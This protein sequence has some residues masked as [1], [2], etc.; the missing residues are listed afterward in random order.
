MHAKRTRG[1]LF[2]CLFLVL[3]GA[4]NARIAHAGEPKS[5]DTNPC[6]DVGGQG[7]ACS[8]STDCIDN[9]YATIC[10][11]DPSQ[12]SFR[13]QIPCETGAEGINNEMLPGECAIGETCR[14][15]KTPDRAAYYCEPTAFRVDLNL[16]DQCINMY[17]EGLAPSF[18]SGDCSLEANLDRLLD[19][20]GDY[21]FDI[22]DL[23]LCIVSFLEQPGCACA[24][25]D[26]CSCCD[27]G[28]FRCEAAAGFACYSPEACACG[29]EA[30]S[31]CVAGEPCPCALGWECGDSAE[32]GGSCEFVTETAVC[33]WSGPYDLICCR[34]DDDCGQ[35][36]Y[37][38]PARHV[39]QRD[40]GVI[41]SREEELEDFERPCAGDLKVCDYARGRCVEIDPTFQG[42]DVD[43]DCPPGAYCFLGTCTPR[44]HRA[45]DCPPGE[46]YC[47][48]T[49]R[50]RALPHPDAEEGFVFDPMN[51]VI[52]FA[53]DE[54]R[55]NGLQNED[56]SELLIMDIASRRQ[57]RGNPSVT[58]GYR[59]VVSYGMKQDAKCLQPFVD[60]SVV[61]TL[62]EG[63]DHEMCKA[64]QDDCYVDD[65]E[66]WIRL[67]APFGV[68][69][70]A[71][72]DGIAIELDEQVMEKL[73]AGEYP[74]TIRAIFD[75]GE[76]DSV[77]VVLSKPS[78]SGE[79]VGD[80]TVY[81]HEVANSLTGNRP[82]AIS[83]RMK[84]EDEL[85]NWHELLMANNL[86]EDETLIDLTSGY[87]VR[88]E[89]HGN[90]AFAFTQSGAGSLAANEVPFIGLYSP[91]MGRLRLLGIIEIA[92]DFCISE[93]GA[94]DQPDDQIQV[95]NPFR[96]L[97]R[98][99]I[100]LIGPFVE[101]T[102]RFHGV[103][104]EKISGLSA[105]A[106]V[107]L[108]GGFILDQL[109]GDDTPITMNDPLL[110]ANAQAVAFPSVNE[111]LEELDLDIATYCGDADAKN[112]ADVK[113]AW[114]AFIT[115]IEDDY[116]QDRTSCKT[117]DS[118]LHWDCIAEG[119]GVGPLDDAILDL[120]E[121]WIYTANAATVPG[122]PLADE[123]TE[124]VSWCIE[125]FF[126]PSSTRDKIVNCLAS[127]I[128]LFNIEGPRLPK[129]CLNEALLSWESA[130]K[131][132]SSSDAIAS[133]LE[134]ELGDLLKWGWKPAHSDIDVVA[135]ASLDWSEGY[136]A[137]AQF[138]STST[139][140]RYLSR[141]ARRAAG[142]PN[143]Y[144]VLGRTTIFPELMDYGD[145]ID[146][147]LGALTP[148][149]G[150]DVIDPENWTRT[151]EQL[152]RWQQ[153]HL[154]IYDYLAARILPCD[155]TA[156]APPPICVATEDARCGLALYRKAIV[157]GWVNM[158]AVNGTGE[159][160]LFCPDT[161]ELAGCPDAG[162]GKED[163]FALQEHNRY[164]WNLGQALKFDGDRAR[165]DAFLVLFRNE[166][167][168]FLQQ[169]ALAYKSENLREA[170]SRYDELVHEIVGPTAAAV[171]DLWPARAFKQWGYDWLGIMQE[172][173][174]A[175][176]DA[177]AELVD[178]E[179]RVFM[180]T[181]EDEFIFAQHMM[182]HEYL[183]HVYLMALQEKWQQ[184]NFGYLGWAGPAFQKG[185]SVLNQLDPTRNSLG[186]VGSR[187]YFENSNTASSNWANYHKIL[188][189]S[190][191]GGLLGAARATVSDGV[192]EL[193]AALADLDS[194]ELKLK[195]AK[196]GFKSTMRSLCGRSVD[197]EMGE[198]PTMITSDGVGV[199]YCEHLA[200][201]VGLDGNGDETDEWETL[202]KCLFKGEGVVAGECSGYDVGFDCAGSTILHCGDVNKTFY[203]ETAAWTGAAS[204]SST[205]TSIY[206]ERC[207]VPRL[208]E[209]H[210]INVNGVP[211]VC[212]GGSM[213]GLLREKQKIELKRRINLRKVVY[214]LRQM[215][216]EIELLASQLTPKIVY[217]VF[218]RIADAVD[219]GLTIAVKV[220]KV[221]EKSA[222][223]MAG[224]VKC[225]IIGGLAVGTNC[226]QGLASGALEVVNAVSHKS[227]IAGLE[228]IQRI[229]KFVDATAKDIADLIALGF[230]TDFKV[231]AKAR[232]VESLVDE[233]H[234]LTLDLMHLA[235]KIDEVHYK[236]QVAANS[237]HK[238]AKFVAEHIVGRE[239][240]NLLKGDQ[241]VQEASEAFQEILLF[242]YKMTMAFI[243]HFNV[244]DGEASNLINQ[245]LAAT[246][247]DD[248]QALA[249]E[250]A[251]RERDY[252]GMEA[253]DCDA[254][255][256]VETLRFSLRD[257]L[258]GHLRD[259]VDPQ[260][261][262]VVTAGQQFHNIITNAPYV[263]RR[264]RGSQLVDQIE[265]TFDVPVNLKTNAS[266]QAPQWLLDPLSCN[267]M[268]DARDPSKSATYKT[269]TLA[270]NV[271]GQNFGDGEQ[272]VRYELVR[273]AADYIRSCQAESVVEEIGTMPV[274][275]YPTRKHV[276]GYAPQSSAAAQGEPTA[277]FTKSSPFTACMNEAEDAG[278][279]GAGYC[280]KFFARDRSLATTGSKIILP[281]YIGD[282]LTDNTW[283]L[284][285][286]LPDEAR[287][288][289]EDI[290]IYY[291]YRARPIQED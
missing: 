143:E 42:C 92:E 84:V 251:D 112:Q 212:I 30:G 142:E 27:V 183:M 290:V 168:P 108:E 46:W 58:F 245:C 101:A 68:I 214:L 49:N 235:A 60:C 190:G 90:E 114:I 137:W 263:K 284:G 52:R 161:L 229:A 79:Y 126:E 226:P 249:D 185:Q 115:A 148:L 247:L 95:K 171:L 91:D 276:V 238:K 253:I 207:I 191:S 97:I 193:R 12:N 239:T 88:A 176:M 264:Q 273:D 203:D 40:C 85:T 268:L 127:E 125:N 265:L 69:S 209:M 139:F 21:S 93:D 149:A 261:N 116:N 32:D 36:L 186:L 13:C 122:V 231:L 99:Q 155:A 153:T 98:R 150:P 237:F 146:K 8:T 23:D 192:K 87:L 232:S 166:V 61:D 198:E 70:G 164:W 215:Q 80:L 170:V 225:T 118:L 269:G 262:T 278:S 20:N 117:S 240:G 2:A 121:C 159:N 136:W 78:L 162:A 272:R 4:S 180:G 197:G 106:D 55:L 107:T 236:A 202:R 201:L 147:A 63:E 16:L 18:S 281:L 77:P 135:D 217:G 86:A 246:T 279:I 22:F 24:A 133:C 103:Y 17:L 26:G 179:R 280:W 196:S 194:L 286:G 289:I 228:V 9:A 140:R 189:G 15:G 200:Q 174:D 39:C 102:G 184:E 3:A 100:E 151:P 47:D 211:R 144:S 274:L 113:Q 199:P 167:N 83:L 41:S 56:E 50:C 243:H 250:L 10:V 76:S 157:K 25:D 6:V 182:Q 205:D 73:S 74:A 163:L 177:I 220:L 72:R 96:R 66:Q 233:Y 282:G 124:G 123:F 71:A 219:M 156:E 222:G 270:V 129:D 260:T 204:T 28:G 31:T 173:V 181:G 45:V 255:S 287:P 241:L 218:H 175:R 244:P 38:D 259:R 64:R 89:L 81:M 131:T 187:V 62:P 130:C 266:S 256:N 120:E 267:H 257:Q 109:S 248:I 277:F 275:D 19:Q 132:E 288:V 128:P 59:L 285:E 1:A 221:T 7:D 158:S 227:I 160:D 14:E 34:G 230:A 165:S 208:D 234:V 57:V 37:C 11:H 111:T 178:L 75:N 82:L 254:A 94:C 51:Y 44:C 5:F 141:S 54:L 33:A 271:I 258:F 252:C 134:T 48:A 152:A 213:G 210:W 154:N 43:S 105:D 53:R 223:L 104:R 65:T 242:S 29:D 119:L 206:G 67:A 291:R 145:L 224:K 172:V 283:I 138:V 188:V 195:A 110:P 216:D 35:G 169:S